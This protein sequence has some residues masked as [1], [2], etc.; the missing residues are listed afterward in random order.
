MAVHSVNRSNAL[1]VTVLLLL[2]LRPNAHYCT[3]EKKPRA[4]TPH[5]AMDF[6]SQTHTRIGHDFK[7][8]PLF[9]KIPSMTRPRFRHI[10]LY[11]L[12]PAVEQDRL[13]VLFEWHGSNEGK[14][15][16]T[17]LAPGG[18]TGLKCN[19]PKL[20]GG[21]YTADV[22]PRDL[23]RKIGGRAVYKAYCKLPATVKARFKHMECVNVTI[24]GTGVETQQHAGKGPHTMLTCPPSFQGHVKMAMCMATP[25]YGFATIGSKI[26]Q[27]LE[28]YAYVMSEDIH[29][30]IYVHRF[31]A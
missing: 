2:L 24:T 15:W 13:D 30:Y 16:T 6:A 11:Q 19:F 18:P 5:L 7:Q 26:A 27:W 23:I 17:V 12:A 31:G 8:N 20:S 4:D 25:M 29:F 3:A 14:N 22:I 1:A 21:Y 28:Y 9:L 10:T